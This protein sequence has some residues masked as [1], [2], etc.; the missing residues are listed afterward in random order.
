VRLSHA[1]Q[2]RC[3]AVAAKNRHVPEIRLA[4]HR[5]A[6]SQGEQLCCEKVAGKIAPALVVTFAKGMTLGCMFRLGWHDFAKQRGSRMKCQQTLKLAI[7]QTNG[8]HHCS[9]L[10]FLLDWG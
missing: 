10:V 2:A 5:F 3:N 1:K 8:L 7:R 4:K 6:V 9:A